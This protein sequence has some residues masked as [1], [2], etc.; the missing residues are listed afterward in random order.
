MPSRSPRASDPHTSHV[1]ICFRRSPIQPYS[2]KKSDSNFDET[3]VPVSTYPQPTDRKSPNIRPLLHGHACA[4]QIRRDQRPVSVN[5]Q[6]I[7][8]RKFPAG[9][10]GPLKCAPGQPA[11]IPCSDEG[12]MGT[13]SLRDATTLRR[14]RRRR[15]GGGCPAFSARL[16][17]VPRTAARL[18]AGNREGRFA[19]LFRMCAALPHQAC[20]DGSIFLPSSVQGGSVGIRPPSVACSGPRQPAMAGVGAHGHRDRN[21]RPARVR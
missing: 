18:E 20:A 8:S 12:G 9:A 11:Q 10:A 13:A 7:P 1:P 6:P 2:S 5:P 17:A 21:G 14:L 16:K 19:C 15:Q 4:T 3:S